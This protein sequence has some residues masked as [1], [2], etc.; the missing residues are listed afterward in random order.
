VLK[1]QEQF[2]DA[3]SNLADKEGDLADNEVQRFA[4][5]ASYLLERYSSSIDS[6]ESNY[7]EL[8]D[9][10]MG[11]HGTATFSFSLDDSATAMRQWFEL[12]VPTHS[13][14]REILQSMSEPCILSIL[15]SCSQL[16]GRSNQILCLLVNVI[17]ALERYQQKFLESTQG[18]TRHMEDDPHVDAMSDDF[19]MMSDDEGTDSDGL[20]TL[21]GYARLLGLLVE[22]V[23]T[24][25][26]KADAPAKTAFLLSSDLTKAVGEIFKFCSNL[27]SITSRTAS[28]DQQA[29]ETSVTQFILERMTSLLKTLDSFMSDLSLQR[30]HVHVSG[31]VSVLMSQDESLKALLKAPAFRKSRPSWKSQINSLAREIG[32]VCLSLGYLFSGDLA[33]VE[34]GNLIP[35]PLLREADIS[36]ERLSSSLLSLFHFS[37]SK[38]KDVCVQDF[39]FS[40]VA[41]ALIGFCGSAVSTNSDGENGISLSDF[42]DSDESATEWFE[43]EDE[44]GEERSK[45][46]QLLRVM[47]QVRLSIRGNYFPQKPKLTFVTDC[48]ASTADDWYHGGPSNLEV[49]LVQRLRH[50][51]WSFASIDCLPST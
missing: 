27:P 39:L 5:I 6:S 34:D 11:V 3:V 10:F 19:S 18:D 44:E 33:R 41:A 17:R 45:Y 37:R 26:E 49:S 9:D 50:G 42:V 16:D 31:L 48:P 29:S 25:F 23:E 43:D 12:V 1:A 22:S 47:T 13:I 8:L 21:F 46:G 36:I 51:A 2:I 7:L 20:A 28:R 38:F 4:S 15:L 30:K 32:Y 24:V 40:P 14:D 35:S